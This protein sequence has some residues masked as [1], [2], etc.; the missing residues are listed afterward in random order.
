MPTPVASPTKSKTTR[1]AAEAR[2]TTPVVKDS[3]IASDAALIL[4]AAMA[5]DKKQSN[6]KKGVTRGDVTME[7]VQYKIPMTV[8]VATYLSYLTIV[9]IGHFRD[10]VGKL[11]WPQQYSHLKT[12]NVPL[13]THCR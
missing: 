1:G 7:D 5:V 11:F 3:P 13:L 8:L 6:K 4:K 10:V 2:S 9:I 12:Q